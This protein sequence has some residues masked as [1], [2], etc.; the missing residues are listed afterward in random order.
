MRLI[1]IKSKHGVLIGNRVYTDADPPFEVEDGKAKGLIALGLAEGCLPPV[2]GPIVEHAV[3]P[4]PARAEK[5]V[6]RR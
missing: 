4:A 6:F 1:K 2:E 3:N 5:A